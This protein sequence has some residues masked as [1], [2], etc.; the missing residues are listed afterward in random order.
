V[1]SKL[2]QQTDQLLTELIGTIGVSPLRALANRAGDLAFG[3]SLVV[4]GS[5]L[6][7][8]ACLLQLTHRLDDASTEDDWLLAREEII[9]LVAFV[10]D[11]SPPYLEKLGSVWK[12]K[13]PAPGLNSLN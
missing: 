9:A 13:K 7:L 2:L 6:I 8:R 5:L 1:R 3:E 11:P 12:Q 10:R 4:A